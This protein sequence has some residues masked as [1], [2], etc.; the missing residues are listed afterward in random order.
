MT[1]ERES[2]WRDPSVGLRMVATAMIIQLI[3]V[4]FMLVVVMFVIA[5]KKTDAMQG[6][7]MLVAVVGL[8][9]QVMMVVGI[10]RFSRQ[11]PPAPSSGLAQSAGALGIVGLTISL[12]F[13]FV[14][15][16]VTSVGPQSSGEQLASAREAVER[17]P[18]I[19]VLAA[20]VGF[21]AMV[22]LLAAA[23][24]VAEHFKRE[25]LVRRSRTAIAMVLLAAA[26]FAFIKLGVTPTSV[27]SLLAML[28]MSTIVQIAAF[29]NILGTVRG[30]A[31]AVLAPAPPELPRARSL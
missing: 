4:A 17:L 2:E 15:S 10:F 13:L 8:A 7:A 6:M 12:Y 1:S 25:D 5:S 9:A 29:V 11:P 24:R 3:L 20:V 18:R 30:L 22:L 19:E 28:A 23:G 27:T 21:V 31:D 14:L 16:Q 26:V